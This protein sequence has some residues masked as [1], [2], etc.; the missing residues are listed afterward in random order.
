V[1]LTIIGL[2]AIIGMANAM[3]TEKHTD[4][5]KDMMTSDS[6]SLV[7]LLLSRGS[8]GL[9]NKE[10][11]RPNAYE[12]IGN[13]LLAL[14]PVSQGHVKRRLNQQSRHSMGRM[15]NTVADTSGKTMTPDSAWRCQLLLGNPEEKGADGKVQVS[16]ILRFNVDP[17]RE[18][19]TVMVESCIPEGLLVTNVSTP[20]R[21]ADPNQGAGAPWI[22]VLFYEIPFPQIQM[23]LPINGIT[24]PD[25][26]QIPDGDIVCSVFHKARNK[27]D[28]ASFGQGS[29]QFQNKEPSRIPGISDKVVYEMT[30]CGYALVL[31]D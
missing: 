28:P 12:H 19:G 14:N 5:R 25:G 31:D 13:L 30:D 10:R 4:I 9:A 1:P 26:T 3:Y 20:F 6:I 27:K 17:K 23:S 15:E 24:C 29:I 8:R 22:Q 21:F 11:P 18:G 7:D 16:A 2:F